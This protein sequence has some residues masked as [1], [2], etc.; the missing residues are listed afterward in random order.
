MG[1]I[2]T[3]AEIVAYFLQALVVMG[4]TAAT[5]WALHEQ[6]IRDQLYL[7]EKSVTCLLPFCLLAKMDDNK[8]KS[9]SALK[10]E[11]ERLQTTLESQKTYSAGLSLIEEAQAAELSSL[12][13]AL[14][15]QHET[16]SCHISKL[17][18]QCE[19]QRWEHGVLI[20]EL[21][22]IKAREKSA[23]ITIMQLEVTVERQNG[24]IKR[25]EEDRDLQRNFSSA[26]FVSYEEQIANLQVK[27]KATEEEADD[28][29]TRA[30]SVVA[31]AKNFRESREHGRRSNR[32]GQRTD[33][34][35][36]ETPRCRAASRSRGNEE[37][38]SG[39][40]NGTRP[41]GEYPADDAKRFSR[42]AIIPRQGESPGTAGA[43]SALD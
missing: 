10:A 28:H 20:R 32:H 33:S 6:R 35:P 18:Q 31:Q 15:E 26:K 43:L 4:P 14:L 13:I 11:L 39:S 30:E 34:W 12:Q 19:A 7:K 21:Q 3:A 9:I 37:T 38:A 8:T 41:H 17:T 2:P 27:I 22:N 23:E 25:L 42:I 40:G 5:A 1:I 29:I 24:M 36:G 16:S